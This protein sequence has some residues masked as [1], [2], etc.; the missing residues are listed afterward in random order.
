MPT[1]FHVDDFLK[2]GLPGFAA[3]I[4]ILIYLLV[5]ALQKQKHNLLTNLLLIGAFGC[6]AVY[7]LELAYGNKNQEA[8][9]A[10]DQSQSVSVTETDMVV[11]RAEFSEDTNTAIGDKKI[12][13]VIKRIAPSIMSI[14]R[15]QKLGEIGNHTFPIQIDVSEYS[16]GTG[17]IHKKDVSVEEPTITFPKRSPRLLDDVTSEQIKDVIVNAGF[18]SPKDVIDQK[19]ELPEGYERPESYRLEIDVF[20]RSKVP[21]TSFPP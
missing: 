12:N 20:Y 17:V 16:G 15:S 14:I 6:F 10:K 2:N 19:R 1:G 8:A 5:S 11:E 3:L 18:P 9:L 21:K 13:E 7:L 4:L